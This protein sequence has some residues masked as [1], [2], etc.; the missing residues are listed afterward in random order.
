MPGQH[1]LVLTK[2]PNGMLKLVH[3]KRV[4]HSSGGGFDDTRVVITLRPLSK[5][6]EPPSLM[7][8]NDPALNPI[9][10]MEAKISKKS[11]L[12]TATKLEG[13]D[14]KRVQKRTAP[15]R[16]LATKEDNYEGEV[17]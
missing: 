4:L 7:P 9:L 12:R 17:Y 2:L 6:S 5:Y 1:N 11:S 3:E 13:Q 16:L 10:D 8:W 15:N 14:G